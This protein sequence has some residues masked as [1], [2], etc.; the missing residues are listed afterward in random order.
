MGGAHIN[1]VLAG[2]L[3]LLADRSPQFLIAM[4]SKDG[5]LTM[6]NEAGENTGPLNGIMLRTAKML[7]AG[8][9]PVYVFDG[10]PPELKRATLDD[11]RE[12]RE[13]VLSCPIPNICA[14]NRSYA[15]VLTCAARSRPRRRS[16]RPRRRGTR[17]LWRSSPSATCG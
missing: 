7:E 4:Q 17:R 12:K 8:I 5:T 2:C 10:K 9:K 1:E 3:T 14:L 11:R 13:E 15:G 16:R 6:T